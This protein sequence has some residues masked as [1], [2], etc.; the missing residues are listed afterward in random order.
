MKAAV[1]HGK[2]DLRVEEVNKPTIGPEDVL[3]AVKAVGICGSDLHLYRGTWTIETP[4]IIGHE[5]TGEVV[6]VGEKVSGWR[7]VQG[8]QS[9]P[10][11]A[12]GNAT[13]AKRTP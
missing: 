10:W 9:S 3:V 11:S 12:A 1:L 4:R 6:E 7:G 8:S 13:G 2:M 5:M